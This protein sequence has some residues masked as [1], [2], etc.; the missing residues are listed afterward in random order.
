MTDFISEEE[1]R[2][3]EMKPDPE[4][5]GAPYICKPMIIMMLVNAS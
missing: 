1:R 4:I 2:R 5:F 3:D